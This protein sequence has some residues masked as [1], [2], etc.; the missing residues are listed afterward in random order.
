MSRNAALKIS[1]FGILNMSSP[2]WEFIWPYGKRAQ[3]GSIKQAAGGSSPVP[4]RTQHHSN[5]VRV[6]VR[7]RVCMCV[8]ISRGYR[9]IS[10]S[11]TKKRQCLWF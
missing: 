9:A 7:V 6:C 10:M 1:R 5:R 4:N 2:E 3:S 11:V 8:H